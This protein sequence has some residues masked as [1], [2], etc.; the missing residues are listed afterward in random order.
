M[1]VVIFLMI[2][3]LTLSTSSLTLACIKIMINSEAIIAINT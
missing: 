3:H 2:F 1:I